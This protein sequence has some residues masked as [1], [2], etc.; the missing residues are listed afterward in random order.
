MYILVASDR[1]IYITSDGKLYEP[2][3]TSLKQ[4]IFHHYEVFKQGDIV[5]R[6][7][8]KE[9]FTITGYDPYDYMVKPDLDGVSEVSRK[10][11]QEICFLVQSNPPIIKKLSR[12]LCVHK[13]TKERSITSTFYDENGVYQINEPPSTLFSNNEYTL[14]KYGEEI[15][16][17]W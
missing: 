6:L 3:I 9:Q 8:T 4:I 12:Y 2:T 7:S 11:L 16:V 17:E 10:Y 1:R 13:L 5:E 15:E 14:K